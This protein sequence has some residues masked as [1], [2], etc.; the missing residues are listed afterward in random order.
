MVLMY[1]T[2]V[3]GDRESVLCFMSVGFT[4]VEADTPDKFRAA[5]REL[6]NTDHA[7][8]FITE[9]AASM[10]SDDIDKYRSKPLPAV[11]LIPGRSGGLGIGMAQ[12]KNSV[13][14]AVGADILK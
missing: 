13:E 2:G 11:I 3:I 12:I 8:I 14:R 6:A 9:D 7:V 4:V 1:K 10:V 5:L